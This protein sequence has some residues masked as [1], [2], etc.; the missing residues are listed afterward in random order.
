MT[1]TLRS[2]AF[3]HNDSI[4]VRYTCDGE[5]RSPP[6]AW[7]EL[8]DRTA[9]LALVVTDPDAPQKTWTHWLLYNIPPETTAIPEAVT[10]LPA[11]SLVGLNDWR[12]ADYGGPCP[13][14]GRH[15]YVHT[16]Y[17]LDKTLPDLHQPT[18]VQLEQ[19]M[20]GHILAKSELVG[21]YQR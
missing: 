14:R 9:S 8:P 1:L 15:R 7:T 18:R 2:P 10:T 3:S 4:P 11:D 5:N 16:L 13:P 17:A 20:Q 6:L 19:A 12:R 21:T